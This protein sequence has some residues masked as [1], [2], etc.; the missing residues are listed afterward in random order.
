MHLS[1]PANYDPESAQQLAAYPVREVYGRLPEDVAGGGRPSYMARRLNRK[2]L[3]RY[4]AGLR[5]CKIAFNYLLNSACLGNREWSGRWQVRLE[6][7]LHTLRNMGVERLTVSSPYLLERI[8]SRFP[9][10]HIR[11]GVFA[12]IDTPRRARFWQDAGADALTLESFSINRDFAALRA[13]RS[14]VTCELHLIAN[15]PCL[16]NC[17]LQVCHQNG[18]AHASGGRRRLF[19]DYCFLTCTLM[20]LREPALFI[21]SAWIRPE[22]TGEYERMGFEH[23]KL[24]ERDMPTAELVRRV[25]AYSIRQSPE[26]L[27]ELLLPYGFAKAPRRGPLWFMRYFFKPLDVRPGKLLQLRRFA[28]KAG[29]LYG[30]GCRPVRIDSA[31]LGR[32]FLQGFENVS[33]RDTLCESC[34]YCDEIAARAVRIDRAA[35]DELTGM[36]ADIT[37]QLKS[38]SFWHV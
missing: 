15:H 8:K 18:F 9:E 21:R 12:Q 1:V 28:Q 33:C 29:M 27:A 6:R 35:S 14:A 11:I 2:M 38:G 32:D 20:R 30:G 5:D 10:F 17:P 4:V 13:I 22:D 19:I 37:E 24:L 7:F 26:N 16:P 23:F 34:R 31:A 25:R 3:A 36:L